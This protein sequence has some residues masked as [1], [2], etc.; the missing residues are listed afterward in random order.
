MKTIIIVMVLMALVVGAW[1]VAEYMDDSD[2]NRAKYDSLYKHIQDIM[3]EDFKKEYKDY[4][5]GSII[6]LRE[7]SYKNAE[8]TEVLWNEY[9]KKYLS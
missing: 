2:D 3:R 8:R 1:L 5:S 4:V 7:L 6:I 9:A